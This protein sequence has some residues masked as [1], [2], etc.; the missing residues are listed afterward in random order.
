MYENSSFG[1]TK[2]FFPILYFICSHKYPV[3]CSLKNPFILL[4]K[5][6]APWIGGK[7]RGEEGVWDLSPTPLPHLPLFCLYIYTL[8]ISP[9]GK[10]TCSLLIERDGLSEM[11]SAL[12]PPSYNTCVMRISHPHPN[13]LFPRPCFTC[14]RN[15]HNLQRKG[16]ALFWCPG[17]FFSG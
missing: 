1:G 6:K 7:A 15:R 10:V 17:A 5:Q 9:W 2:H 16:I 12:D 11:I 13:T 14:V 4:F 3:L 8:S